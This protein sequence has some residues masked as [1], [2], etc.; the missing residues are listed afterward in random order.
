MDQIKWGIIGCGNVTEVKSGPA[1]NKVPNSQLVA[2]M[3]RD[4]T[5][6]EDY[7]KRHG[8]PKWYSDVDDLINDPEV[9]AVY[10]ATPPNVHEAYAEKAMRAGKPVYVEKPMAMDAAECDRMNAVSEETGVP[11]FV[12]YYRRSLPY[13]TKL[14][15][16]IYS[17]VIGDIRYV[18]ITLQWQPYDEE[19]GEL[20]KPR[21]R[22]QPE[23]SG[24][25]HFH[26][27]ASHQF[28]YLEYVLGPI[29]Q[30][31]GI[32]R[33]Q[34][35]L[36]EADDITVANFEFESGVLGNGVW[37]YTINKEQR[38]DHAQIIGSRG[39]ISFS[40]FE[41]CDIIV[42]TESGTEVYNI[43]Y[44]EHVQQPLIDLIVKELRGE[45]KSPSSGLTGA[46]ANLI[47]DWIT[48][49]K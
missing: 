38:E 24:G 36:Y 44:P 4:A 13:F 19:V 32:A 5:L 14:K 3:R 16:L 9:N 18:N 25:G 30:A 46:R 15:E 47:M 33:N 40:F 49:G 17:N 41:K 39:R 23:I 35:G 6:A 48:K 2:V 21:W 10:I 7:A 28:N 22:V 37:C 11:L 45:G 20:R 12:A 1:F 31:R 29:K 27:L 42:E 26:D 34:A 43:P 8:V